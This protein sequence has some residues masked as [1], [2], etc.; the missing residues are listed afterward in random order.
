[1]WMLT[2]PKRKAAIERLLHGLHCLAE[3]ARVPGCEVPLSLAEGMQ[4]D[5]EA[6]LA[7]AACPAAPGGGL[8]LVATDDLFEEIKR[9]HDGVL[10]LT[11]RNTMAERFEV[12][13]AIKGS[14]FEVAGMVEFLVVRSRCGLLS[15]HEGLEPDGSGDDDGGVQ[16]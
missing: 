5:A 9:R 2:G 7:L 8:E 6:L 12:G 4:A 11:V 1:M 15:M 13:S 16:A 10:L 14:P 3:A